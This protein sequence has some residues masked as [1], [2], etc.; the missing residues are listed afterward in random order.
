MP[1]I[2]VP[3]RRCARHPRGG[4]SVRGMG[5]GRLRSIK[6]E[7][8]IGPD[9]RVSLPTLRF[10]GVPKEAR[11]YFLNACRTNKEIGRSQNMN[12]A[13]TRI[14]LLRDGELQRCRL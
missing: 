10:V 9:V 3:L 11:A 13:I 14:S 8:Q 6:E 7:P 5:A 2:S 4:L 12:A 1:H